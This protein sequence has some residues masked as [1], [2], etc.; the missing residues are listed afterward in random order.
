MN[1]DR[2]SQTLFELLGM[3]KPIVQAPMAGVATPALAA[4]VSEAGGLGSLGVGAMSAEQAREAIRQTRALSRAP[5]NV[6]VFCHAPARRDAAVEQ[7]WLNWL[8]PRFAELGAEPPSS[9]REIYRSF[10]DDQAMQQ[11]LLDERPAVVSF[12][13]GLPGADVVAELK[14][15]GIRLMASVTNPDEARRAVDAGVDVLVAQGIEAGGHRG[16]FDPDAP[17]EGLGVFAL[18]RL[19]VRRFDTP[20][21]AAG[22]IMDGAGIAAVLALGA[23][24]AQLGTA[25]VACAESSADS[26]YRAALLGEPAR[27]TVLTAA[28]SGR[29]AR[30]LLNRHAELERASDRPRV[31]DYPLAYDAARALHAAAVAAGVSGYGAQWAGQG[32]AMARALPAGELVATLEAELAD[33]L[34]PWRALQ[35]G[36]R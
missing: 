25:F 3:R 29:P 8:Q 20:V 17:D 34:R 10:V 18:T 12:H 9:L 7:R 26:R 33:A 36:R 19:L 30:S 11:L 16:V 2:A 6:N 5:F 15:A 23:Q 1:H 22:G 35:P 14:R 32:A 27:H 4:A 13:F 31:P 28:I 21:V 24:A